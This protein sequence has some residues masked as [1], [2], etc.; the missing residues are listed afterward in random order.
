MIDEED[1]EGAS[2]Y[3]PWPWISGFA[4]AG[5][6]MLLMFTLSSGRF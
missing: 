6:L 3:G 5:V 4:L 2:E 1:R